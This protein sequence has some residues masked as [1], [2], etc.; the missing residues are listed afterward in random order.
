MALGKG[1]IFNKY[2]IYLFLSLPAKTFIPSVLTPL[3]SL[4]FF[5]DNKQCHQFNPVCDAVSLPLSVINEEV[6]EHL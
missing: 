5:S 6:W 2:D 4:S 3:F 1:R